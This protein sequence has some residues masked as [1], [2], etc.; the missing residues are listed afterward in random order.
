MA[1]FNSVDV[2]GIIGPAWLV[3]NID[4]QWKDANRREI[5]LKLVRLLE[6]E[7]A[8]MGL[9]THILSISHK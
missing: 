5:I 8:I 4:E 3:P 9:S 1:G 2:R 7:D 6:K